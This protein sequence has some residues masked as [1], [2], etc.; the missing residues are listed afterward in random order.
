[1]VVVELIQFFLRTLSFNMHR[2]GY[3]DPNFVS[4]KPFNL[5][6]R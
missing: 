2:W 1:M 3:P 4:E 6:Q 5:T